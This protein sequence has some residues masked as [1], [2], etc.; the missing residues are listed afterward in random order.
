MRVKHSQELTFDVTFCHPISV[1]LKHVV[2][3]LCSYTALPVELNKLKRD[4]IEDALIL[5]Y[6]KTSSVS[7][8][9]LYS[10][11][12]VNTNDYFGIKL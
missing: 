7:R 4:V 5:Q 11:W 6:F 8:R 3:C 10:F 12:T 9:T 1:Y 2:Y